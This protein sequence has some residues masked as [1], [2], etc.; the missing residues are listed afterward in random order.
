MKKI[1]FACLLILL[2][3]QTSIF[4]A[5][6]TTQNENISLDLELSSYDYFGESY[7]IDVKDNQ[8]NARLKNSLNCDSYLSFYLFSPTANRVNLWL[9]TESADLEEVT[10]NFKQGESKLISLR[11]VGLNIL[12]IK[13]ESESNFLII[14]GIK[15]TSEK[16]DEKSYLLPSLDL[17][18]KKDI[19]E[20]NVCITLYP[21]SVYGVKDITYQ[22]ESEVSAQGDK[23]YFSRLGY[24][25]FVNFTVTDNINQTKSITVTIPK[26]NNLNSKFSLTKGIVTGKIKDVTF[27][28]EGDSYLLAVENI[29]V[30]FELSYRGKDLTVT[31][32]NGVY[33]D[34]LPEIGYT[35][36]AKCDQIIFSSSQNFDLFIRNVQSVD[37]CSEQFYISY[38][39]SWA[40]EL[41][42]P[43]ID[44]PT[45]SEIGEHSIK[46]SNQYV[47]SYIVVNGEKIRSDT[48]SS[49][50]EGKHE[51]IY[52]YDDGDTV[53]TYLYSVNLFDTT[54]PSI[55][56]SIPNIVEYGDVVDLTEFAVFD[57]S[58][59]DVEILL[60]MSDQLVS[61]ANYSTYLGEVGEY[62]LVVSATD[63]S[64]NHNFSVKSFEFEIK[65][66]TSPTLVEFSLLDSVEVFSEIT[67]IISFDDLSDYVINSYY[68]FEEL[69]YNFENSFKANAIGE[70]EIVCVCTDIYGNSETVQK[71]V[72][73]VDTKCPI[74]ELNGVLKFDSEDFLSFDIFSIQDEY[75]S[76]PVVE[77]TCKLN[78]NEVETIANGV[79]YQGYGEYRFTVSATDSSGNHAQEEYTLLLED[80]NPSQVA[81]SGT[82]EIE[83]RE[84]GV[85]GCNGCNGDVSL[86][87]STIILSLF[88]V[89]GKIFLRKK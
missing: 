24:D 71:W 60:Y 12:G 62:M 14:S 39:T 10:I 57:L 64:S 41:I 81:P 35:F 88:L 11:V 26:L 13:G 8:F 28:S 42:I 86:L 73:V 54:A 63:R 69:P 77:I 33:T 31:T 6:A 72:S 78:G 56:F 36:S 66:T 47:Q 4:V 18:I 85:F 37:V 21:R 16:L 34:F 50:I 83:I 38:D 70:Y 58:E 2:I 48:L 9:Y 80:P 49:N 53:A 19:S 68:I 27:A 74:I 32:S 87:D 52:E 3:M 55:S 22:C 5:F 75:D 17:A 59:C 61:D 23:Y 30:E 89:V 15:I 40:N 44:K 76:F 79:F 20:N 67:P 84:D 51:I 43:R 46:C 45:F 65:D 29:G 25:Y 7:K 82:D 1:I